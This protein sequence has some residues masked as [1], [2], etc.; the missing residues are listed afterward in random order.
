LSEIQT[1][2]NNKK[3]NPEAQEE[4]HTEILL[5]FVYFVVNTKTTGERMPPLPG[6]D[7]QA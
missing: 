2:H 3:I 7:E 5:S 6:F 1:N 4:K